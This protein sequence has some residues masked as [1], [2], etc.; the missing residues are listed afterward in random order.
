MYERTR[1]HHTG[2]GFSRL[3]HIVSSPLPH[4]A[5]CSVKKCL[6][7]HFVYGQFA[8]QVGFPPNGLVTAKTAIKKRDIIQI[9]VGNVHTLLRH[10]LGSIFNTD[11][12]KNTAA[13]ISKSQRVV[14]YLNLPQHLFSVSL[15]LTDQS[16]L[17][18]LFVFLHSHLLQILK[19]EAKQHKRFLLSSTVVKP[20]ARG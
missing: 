20:S 4:S 1:N 11:V 6:L 16:L 8:G 13:H 2:R 18:G 10:Q 12:T 19:E 15:Y 3:G 5:V 9:E 14:E 7:F 17:V